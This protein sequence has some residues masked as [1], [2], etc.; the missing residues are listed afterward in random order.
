MSSDRVWCQKGNMVVPQKGRGTGNS[1]KDF[2][3]CWVSSSSTSSCMASC[4]ATLDRD[5]R[6]HLTRVSAN[7]CVSSRVLPSG[8]STAYDSI[9][10]VTSLPPISSSCNDVTDRYFCKRW[11]PPSTLKLKMCWSSSSISSRSTLEVAGIPDTNCT[12]RMLP[13]TLAS[14]VVM[15]QA[16]MKRLYACGFSNLLT[17]DHTSCSG[18]LICCKRMEPHWCAPSSCE[19]YGQIKSLRS[20]NILCKAWV[21]LTGLI[22]TTP[23][24][25]SSFFFSRKSS[26]R[27]YSQSSTLHCRKSCI[28]QNKHQASLSSKETAGKHKTP[29]RTKL[30][31]T[32]TI[33]IKSR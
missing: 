19:W 16:W 8:T 22:T 28:S 5:F 21:P 15:E 23:P 2:T 14:P 24:P 4:S 20:S 9:T 31:E 18:A 29:A 3:L 33:R 27:S 12:V 10:K 13:T 17:I 30:R 26:S 6:L 1:S 32:L 25:S 11:L 7:I